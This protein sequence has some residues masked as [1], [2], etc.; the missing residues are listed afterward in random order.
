MENNF[1]III[2]LSEEHNFAF[3]G[4]WRTTDISEN[5]ICV[6]SEKP[7]NDLYE[8]GD[9]IKVSLFPTGFQ[10]ICIKCSFNYINQSELELRI[11]DF[12]SLK[13]RQLYNNSW[14]TD[15][16]L[17]GIQLTTLYWNQRIHLCVHI[18]E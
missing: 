2:L 4:F 10:S 9:T 15:S 17:R 18:R 5:E 12:L 8:V 16:I 6:K 13:D 7:I 14:Q 1:N 3:H 11:I